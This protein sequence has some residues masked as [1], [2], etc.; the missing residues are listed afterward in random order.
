MEQRTSCRRRNLLEWLSTAAARH[1]VRRH[2]IARGIVGKYA[3]KVWNNVV[4]ASGLTAQQADDLRRGYVAQAG[5]R[6]QQCVEEDADKW[7]W[8]RSLIAS[9]DWESVA[10]SCIDRAISAFHEMHGEGQPE[11]LEIVSIE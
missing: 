5:A 4:A 9:A 2:G 8:R 11:R 10:K 7:A 1:L 3:L 6:L